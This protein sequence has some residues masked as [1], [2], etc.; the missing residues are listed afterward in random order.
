M[1]TIVMAAGATAALVLFAGCTA[2]VSG[3]ARP[4]ADVFRTATV[5]LTIYSTTVDADSCD[6]TDS[7]Y[8]DIVQGEQ[9]KIM[10]GQDKVITTGELSPSLSNT[11]WCEFDAKVH[12]LPSWLSDY[13]VSFG[14]G[15]RGTVHFTRTDLT[16]HGW[17][18]ALSL[19][20]DDNTYS[21]SDG[22]TTT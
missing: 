6:T 8:D 3:S 19:G 5:E 16:G 22:D 21:D 4:A 12:D 9:V 17:V 15:H 18:F 14:D 20:S 7:G 11:D 10:D 1:K 13:N 2:S